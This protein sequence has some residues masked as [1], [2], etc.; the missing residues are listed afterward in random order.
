MVTF[1][2]NIYCLSFSFVSSIGVV[3]VA[4]IAVPLLADYTP[5]EFL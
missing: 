1:C 5:L 4:F 3:F 2:M